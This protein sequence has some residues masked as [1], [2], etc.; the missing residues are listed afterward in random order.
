MKKLVLAVSTFAALLP[1]LAVSA[2]KAVFPHRE[3]HKDVAIMEIGQLHDQLD[4]VVV[5]DVRSRYEFDTLHI[6]GAMHM[7]LNKET[8]PVAARELRKNTDKPIVFY[9]NGTTCE[10]SYIATDLAMKAGVTKVYAYDAGLDAWSQAYPED[11]ILLGRGPAKPADLI[12]KSAFKSRLLSAND[13]ESAMERGGIVLDIRDM[14]QRDVML[15]P[16]KEKRATLDDR[17]KIAQVV[18]E[19][20]RTNKPLLVY[21]KVGKQIRWFQYYLEQE[22]VKQYHFLAGGAEGYHEAKL[23]KFKVTLPDAS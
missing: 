15:F 3:K 9:C 17:T 14:R 4:K 16:F 2:E 13:F 20:K 1:I 23:G 19:A 6:K 18:A 11:S 8:L 5:V 10:K 21:D 22:G 12:G 7:P